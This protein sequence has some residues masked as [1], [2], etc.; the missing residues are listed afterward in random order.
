LRLTALVEGDL[1]RAG[2]AIVPFFISKG[3]SK[4]AMTASAAVFGFNWLGTPAIRY[5]LMHSPSLV[6]ATAN[7][8]DLLG[9]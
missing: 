4:P 1:L 9:E 2:C 5:R 3:K 7:F 8:E 6:H